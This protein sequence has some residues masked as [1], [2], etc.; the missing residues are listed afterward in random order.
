[1]E[2]FALKVSPSL[3]VISLIL[4]DSKSLEL[5][6]QLMDALTFV[7]FAYYEVFERC[8]SA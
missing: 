5:V 7:Y 2:A 1:M 6:I 3:L 4:R 8:G